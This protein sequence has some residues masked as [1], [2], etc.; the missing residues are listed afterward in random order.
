M[1]ALLE[2]MFDLVM[3]PI[4]LIGLLFVGSTTIV[5][6]EWVLKNANEEDKKRWS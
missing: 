3:L 5:D 1:F 4:N 6:K 2:G